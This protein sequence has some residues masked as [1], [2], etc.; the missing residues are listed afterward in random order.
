M[1]TNKWIE[2]TIKNKGALRDSLKAKDSTKTSV[3][4]INV[5]TV[6]HARLV[7]TLRGIRR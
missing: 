5:T 3:P 7:K 6:R 4:N 2:K 1:S